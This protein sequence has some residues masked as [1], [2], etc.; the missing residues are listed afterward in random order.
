MSKKQHQDIMH[1]TGCFFLS[2][3]CSPFP[4]KQHQETMDWD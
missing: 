3:N 2:F 4:E 1:C